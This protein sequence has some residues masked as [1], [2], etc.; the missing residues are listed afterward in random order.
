MSDGEAGP[1][2][3]VDDDLDVRE[4]LVEALRDVGYP[5]AGATDGADAL[6]QLQAGLR[7]SLVL[8]DWMMPHMDGAAFRAAQ[9]A[10][11]A[12]A[13]IPVVVVTADPRAEERRDELGVA[14]VLRKPVRLG[15]LL[16]RVERHR[17]R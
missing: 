15:E 17:R 16:E 2:L 5:V 4:A 10:D 1:I 9:L 12:L 3:V 6:A 11:E 14:D 8:L 7:P 13:A